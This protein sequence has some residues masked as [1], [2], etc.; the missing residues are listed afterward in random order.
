V[1]DLFERLA[2]WHARDW[3]PSLK[4]LH[5]DNDFYDR[6]EGTSAVADPVVRPM[7]HMFVGSKAPWWEIEDSLP[8]HQEWVSFEPASAQQK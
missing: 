8:Q 6:R 5:V 3:N 1:I 4:S 2:H 7:L